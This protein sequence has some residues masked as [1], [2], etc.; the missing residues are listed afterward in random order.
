HA[1]AFHRAG[2]GPAH[3]RG[4]RHRRVPGATLARRALP[5][6][7]AAR[8]MGYQE[9]PQ[10]RLLSRRS[11]RDARR[12]REPLRP[13][14]RHALERAGEGRSHR[15]PEIHLTIM[16]TPASIARHPIHP[17]LVPIPIGLWIFSF[18][19]DLVHAFGAQGDAWTTLAL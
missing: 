14:L 17:M 2:M 13:A 7:A 15:I 11:L 10:G 1:A 9:D 8:A 5:H 6:D 18:V 12:R 19:C 3:G 16:Q 4:N